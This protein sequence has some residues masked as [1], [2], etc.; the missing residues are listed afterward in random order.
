MFNITRYPRYRM[1]PCALQLLPLVVSL[2]LKVVM[3]VTVIVIVRE[4]AMRQQQQSDNSCRLPAE[5]R[6]RRINR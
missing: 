6:T 2:A 1:A 3:V 4:D 5:L